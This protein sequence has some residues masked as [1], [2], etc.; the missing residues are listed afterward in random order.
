[1]S[2]SQP[3]GRAF[4]DDQLVS[5]M[6]DHVDLSG[7]RFDRV[8]FSR[9]TFRSIDF[10]GADLRNVSLAD[11]Q[12]RGAYLKKVEI[13]GEVVDVRVNGVDIGPLL[14]A[15]LD[16]QHPERIR[17]QPSDADGFRDAWAALD[18]LWAGTVER[19][20]QL[21]AARPGILHESVGGEWSFIQTLRHLPFAT[22][23]WLSRGIQHDPSP[24]HPLELPWDEMAPTEGVPHDRD[25]QPSLDEALTLRTDRF[26]RVRTHLASLTDGDLASETTVPPGAG[27]PP[28]GETFP[29]KEALDTLINEE[30]WHRQFAERDL[31]KLEADA[32]HAGTRHTQEES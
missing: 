17:L 8:D 26:E 32:R 31:S 22:S 18:D 10:D 27:W 21:E 16:R 20:R 23:S 29:V 9:S 7:S 6:F 12:V 5:S 14:S 11:V 28:A 2:D 1:M 15:E 4:R 13:W 25:A 24:W 3:T 30:W 19:A